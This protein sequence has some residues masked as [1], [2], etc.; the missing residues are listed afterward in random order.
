MARQ[1]KQT[2][3]RKRTKGTRTVSNRPTGRPRLYRH[4]LARVQTYLQISEQLWRGDYKF[5][6][7]QALNSDPELATSMRQHQNSTR[8]RCKVRLT[9]AENAAPLQACTEK[10]D[11]R[12]A[13]WICEMDAGGS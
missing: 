11:L 6:V 7:A 13:E 8:G 4:R 2:F 10:E 3:S 12:I 5:M 9:K 1:G